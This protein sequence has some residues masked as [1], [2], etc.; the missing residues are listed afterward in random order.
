MVVKFGV[1]VYFFIL[2]E[3]C[4]VSKKCGLR[5]VIGSKWWNNL[6]VLEK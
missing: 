5:V 2:V 1:L 4:K 6:Y 3:K